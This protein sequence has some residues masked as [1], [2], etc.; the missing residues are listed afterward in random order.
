M[1]IANVIKRQAVRTVVP[2]LKDSSD[3]N[4]IRLLTIAEKL[5]TRP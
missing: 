5:A 4:L 1:K 2:L 3:A